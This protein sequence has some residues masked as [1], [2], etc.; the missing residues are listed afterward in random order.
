MVRVPALPEY[1]G[2]VWA[3]P[4][5]TAVGGVAFNVLRNLV[6]LGR[7]PQALIPVGEGIWAQRV[8]AEL[9]TLGVRSGLPRRQSDN[10]WVLSLITP[11][12]ERTFVTTVGCEREW[13][14]SELSAVEVPERA[15]VSVSGFQLT[16]PNSQLIDWLESLPASATVVVDP[17][18]RAA[19]LAQNEELAQRV[20]A[21]ADV[22]SLNREEAQFLEAVALNCG[23]KLVLRAGAEGA[24]WVDPSSPETEVTVPALPVDVVDTVGAG[25]AHLAAVLAGLADGEEPAEMMRK[26]NAL[27]ARV[28]SGAGPQGS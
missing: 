24:R 1:A 6:R 13:P 2:H 8:L 9:Q 22:V 5:L 12:G 19:Q 26:A 23:C 25:D 3:E 4:V 15:I 10:G 17:G 16:L 14:L 7:Q 11:D 27:A 28:V 20:F 21:R 18:A